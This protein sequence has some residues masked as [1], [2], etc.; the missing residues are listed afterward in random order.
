MVCDPS[1][2]RVIDLAGFRE[3]SQEGLRLV[4]LDSRVSPQPI[5]SAV[6]TS[7]LESNTRSGLG[8]CLKVGMLRPAPLV[9][10]KFWQ[11]LELSLQTG[12]LW[13]NS[14]QQTRSVWLAVLSAMDIN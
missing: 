7:H 1:R 8:G 6:K 3:E 10:Y 4:Q 9:H 14:D 2:A 5:I 11:K 12:T 13:G